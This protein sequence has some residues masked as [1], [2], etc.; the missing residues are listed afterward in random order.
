MTRQLATAYITPRDG[1][2][3]AVTPI[4]QRAWYIGMASE[5][6]TS[7]LHNLRQRPP[8]STNRPSRVGRL[9][10]STGTMG[11]WS[12]SLGMPMNLHT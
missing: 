5:R 11:D 3:T 9:S 4:N 6:R 2:T 12:T 7:A 8:T 1:N 10:F